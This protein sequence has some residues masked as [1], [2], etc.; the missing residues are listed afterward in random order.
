MGWPTAGLIGPPLVLPRGGA[1]ARVLAWTPQVSLGL[2]FSLLPS[3]LD[4]SQPDQLCTEKTSM[5]TGACVGKQ[6]LNGSDSAVETG[7]SQ[8]ETCALDVLEF[9][10]PVCRARDSSGC[11]PRV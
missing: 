10:L 9:D 7:S 6:E 3:L 4:L 5:W 2:A 11:V 8:L 1:A